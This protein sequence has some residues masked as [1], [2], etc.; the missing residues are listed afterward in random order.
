MTGIT[1][2]IRTFGRIKSRTIKPRQASMMETLLPGLTLPEAPFDPVDRMPRS[3]ERWLEIGFGGGEHMAERAARRPDVLFL[4]A[5]P[6]LNGV[7]SALRYI[8]EMQLENV[9]LHSGDARDL[10]A[11]L[12]DASLDRVF[13]L[14]PDPWPK[15][16][17][18]KRRLVGEAFIGEAARVM[19]SGARLSFATDWEDYANWTLGHFL[20]SSDF[21]WTAES[22]DDWRSAPDDH[23]PTR[24]EAKRL[25]DCAPLWLEFE[26]R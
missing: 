23:V 14:F 16:R 19:K 6:F 13:V 18:R 3:T 4:G 12:P 17:H 22:A 24:Y 8:E 10:M 21:R 25:G 20:A 5:E 9:R 11:R 15:A 7:A 1:R 26:R 2:P